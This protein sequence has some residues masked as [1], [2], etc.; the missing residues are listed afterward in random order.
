MSRVQLP[1]I[2][3]R[4]PRVDIPTKIAQFFSFAAEEVYDVPETLDQFVSG[5][6]CLA[7]VEDQLESLNYEDET[8]QEDIAPDND[9]VEEEENLPEITSVCD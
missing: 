1:L 5:S 3:L 6:S 8:L 7:F 2:A 4:P 9:A